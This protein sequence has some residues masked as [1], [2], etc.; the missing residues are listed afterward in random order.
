MQVEELVQQFAEAKQSGALASVGSYQ[1]LPDPSL[2]SRQPTTT[3][4]RPKPASPPVEEQS[5]SSIGTGLVVL[6][7]A[8]GAGVGVAYQ[9]K[10]AS[11]PVDFDP[12]KGEGEAKDFRDSIDL[13]QSQ[14]QTDNPL[15]PDTPADAASAATA[16]ANAA[17]AASA[18]AAAA[19]QAAAHAASFQVDQRSEP[20]GVAA[21][22]GATFDV[23]DAIPAREKKQRGKFGGAIQKMGGKSKSVGG[24]GAN[25][26]RG[27]G[28][29]PHPHSVCI[30]LSDTRHL[31]VCAC[32]C[33]I[34]P[35]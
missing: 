29:T 15:S 23:E 9:K 32:S 3:S 7:L 34:Y 12:K 11:S 4:R 5:S 20:S 6:L 31:V 8:I 13:E 30:F 17:I 28:P 27:I 21:A 22:P 1:S 10:F 14:E 16:A 26:V 25:L 33:S 19:A 24:K 2:P 35:A 18:A